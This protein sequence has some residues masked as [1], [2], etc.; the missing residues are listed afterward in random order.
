VALIPAALLLAGGRSREVA[1]SSV[2]G[3]V[4]GVGAM[5][6]A[7]ATWGVQAGSVGFLVGSSVNLVAVLA[8]SFFPTKTDRI[9][10]PAVSDEGSTPGV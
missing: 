2:V 3:F 6:A 10:P 1:L 8:L 4:V 5:F 7:A 9:G